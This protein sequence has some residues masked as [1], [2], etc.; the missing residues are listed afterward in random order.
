[1]TLLFKNSDSDTNRTYDLLCWVQILRNSS[2]GHAGNA[3]LA[4]RS[5]RVRKIPRRT[6]QLAEAPVC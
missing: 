3:Q 4:I 2:A 6:K 5:V 1:M